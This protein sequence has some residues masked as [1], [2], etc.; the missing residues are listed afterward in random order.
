MSVIVIVLSIIFLFII[1]VI[2]LSIFGS[3][4][5]YGT[6]ST[7]LLIGGYFI[8]LAVSVII[9]YC[10]PKS[11]F[12]SSENSTQALT[13]D[14]IHQE[15]EQGTF[16]DVEAIQEKG[17][18]D[19]TF[20]KE[21]L[22]IQY[23]DNINMYTAFDRKENSDQTI[24]VIYY[25]ANTNFNGYD[26]YEEIPLPTVS[27]EGNYLS[28]DPSMNHEVKLYSFHND[29][30]IS[31]FRGGGITDEFDSRHDDDTPLNYE[32]LIIRVPKNLELT[33]SEFVNF[34]GE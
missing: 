2:L 1:A 30:V 6:K 14:Q 22:N 16:K 9:Y 18:W 13:Y 29:F 23:L 11:S 21:K 20:N 7:K 25:V 5:S 24:E 26:F 32:F 33:G 15:I 8:I 27:L 4:K 34:L 17:K 31:Q 28:A 10:I 3:K 19:F 12:F